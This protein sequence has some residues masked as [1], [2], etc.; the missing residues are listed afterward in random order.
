MS[1]IFRSFTSVSWQFMDTRR[2]PVPILDITGE[3]L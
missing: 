1:I 2:D 3:G